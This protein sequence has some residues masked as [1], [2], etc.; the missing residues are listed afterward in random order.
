MLD[1]HKEIVGTMMSE[2]APPL[3]DLENQ[4]NESLADLFRS[5]QITWETRY[6]RNPANAKQ[7]DEQFEFEW[8]NEWADF[9][10]EM[11]KGRLR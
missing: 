11:A 4:T 3:D 8:M 5:N 7:P 10:D 9:A 2:S 6:P 1:A